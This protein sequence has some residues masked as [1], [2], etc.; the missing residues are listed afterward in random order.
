VHEKSSNHLEGKMPSRNDTKPPFKI[1]SILLLLG[2]LLSTLNIKNVPAASAQEGAASA[3]SKTGESFIFFDQL[4]QVSPSGTNAALVSADNLGM[5]GS[6]IWVAN[7]DGTDMRE[8]VKAEEGYWITNPIWSP[9]SEKIAY[10]RVVPSETT[11]FEIRSRFEIWVISKDGSENR[12]ITD[13]DLLNPALGYGGKTD[14]TWNV[15]NEIEFY[16]Q[17]EFPIKKYA[18][19]LDTLE[20]GEINTPISSPDTIVQAQPVN[21]PRFYQ[22]DSRWSSQQLGTCNTTI[23]AEGCAITA[24]A[25]VFSYYGVTTDPGLLNTWLKN[26]QGYDQG[27]RIKWATY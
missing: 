4:K 8:L 13:T 17:A 26:N 5:D 15:N 19:D 7:A 23:G 24:T 18:V 16:N 25:M 20:V 11:S 27:C 2:I 14:L 9:D 6:T 21:V 12:Q 3:S 10:L 22:T 1:I